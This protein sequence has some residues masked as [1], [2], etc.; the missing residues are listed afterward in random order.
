[1]R[2]QIELRFL[3]KINVVVPPHSSLVTLVLEM[4]RVDENVELMYDCI[5]G[6][7]TILAI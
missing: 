6:S 2:K 3:L 4:E 7:V 1:M 5:D